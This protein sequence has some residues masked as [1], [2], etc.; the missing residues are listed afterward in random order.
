MT[1]FS[2]P[3]V[4]GCSVLRRLLGRVALLWLRRRGALLWRRRIATLGVVRRRLLQL[5][6]HLYMWQRK[7]EIASIG[8]WK[9]A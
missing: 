7:E 5:A 2:Y 8:N 3:Y 1:M 6:T 4:G 9:I